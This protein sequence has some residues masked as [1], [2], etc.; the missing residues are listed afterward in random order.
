MQVLKVEEFEKRV[1]FNISKS[2][3]HQ[4]KKGQSYHL[5]NS[6]VGIT[7]CNFILWEHKIPLLSRWHMQEQHTQEL[8]LPQIQYT[9]L[10]LP[11]YTG[12]DKPKNV[13]EKWAYFFQQAVSFEK[14]PSVL[15]QAP[16]LEALETARFAQFNYEELELYDREKILEQ[17]AR[18]MISLADKEGVEKGLKKGL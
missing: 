4:L 3:V 7:I 18:G 9:F 15:N 11:K 16:Y 8:G 5:L 10:E 1:V 13:I 17:D 12:G 14:I 2:Y 6:V